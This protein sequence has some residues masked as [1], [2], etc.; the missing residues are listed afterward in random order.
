MSISVYLPGVGP[1]THL[2]ETGFSE[3][4][5]QRAESELSFGSLLHS[6]K[7]YTEVLS[8]SPRSI[9]AYLN[10]S[11]VHFGLGFAD[12][13]AGDAYRALLLIDSVREDDDHCD[14]NI[15]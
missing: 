9:I 7:L 11:L 10:R 14:M 3:S 13:A 5:I 1:P 15:G 6:R 8:I 4:L 2:P 12:L